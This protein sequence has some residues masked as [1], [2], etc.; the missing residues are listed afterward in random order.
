[1]WGEPRSTLDI[2]ITI[3]ARKDD[4][5]KL[6]EHL[7]KLCYPRVTDPGEFVRETSVLPM[8]TEDEVRIDIIFAGLPF[9][10]EAIRR[11]VDREIR[12]IPVRFITPEDLIVHKIISERQKDWKDVR[13]IV[14]RQ[15]GKLDIKYLDKHIKELADMLERPE[16]W[17][18]WFKWK[19]EIL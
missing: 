1:V 19:E 4:T 13:G 8:V 16:M 12:G 10:L 7:K 11:A 9:E 18:S 15:K 14:T 17:N 6:I 3:Q 5:K 2:D